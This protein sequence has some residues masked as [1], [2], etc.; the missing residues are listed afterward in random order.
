ML[1]AFN[2]IL[3]FYEVHYENQTFLSHACSVFVALQQFAFTAVD[4]RMDAH[5]SS[6]NS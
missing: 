2:C 6:K 5:E 1:D 3:T 4:T